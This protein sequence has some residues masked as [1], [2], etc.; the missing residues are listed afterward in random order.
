MDR[1]LLTIPQ[2]QI[3]GISTGDVTLERK[4]GKF[5]LAAS[6]PD[7]K[8]NETAIYRLVGALTYPAFDAVARQRRRGTCQGERA[9]HRGDGQAHRRRAPSS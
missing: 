4:D 3:A 2:D 9:K 6:P 7:E 8:P 1:S 5:V